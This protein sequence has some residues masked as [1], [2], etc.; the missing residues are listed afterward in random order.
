MDSE[1]RKRPPN[2]RLEIPGDENLKNRIQENILVNNHAVTC[3]VSVCMCV[4]HNPDIPE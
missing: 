4:I 2:F 3:S 1:K